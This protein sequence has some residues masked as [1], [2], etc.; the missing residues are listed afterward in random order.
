VEEI[1]QPFCKN[2]NWDNLE[3]WTPRK[4]FPWV[5]YLPPFIFLLGTYEGEIFIFDKIF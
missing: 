3:G 4:N 2:G 5:Y 1:L